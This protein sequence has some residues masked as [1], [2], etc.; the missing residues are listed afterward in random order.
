MITNAPTHALVTDS[1]M[2]AQDAPDHGFVD[3]FFGWFQQS[4]CA[5]HG[6]DS[7]LQYERNRIFLRC[8]S[9]G[10]ESPGWEMTGKAAATLHPVDVRPALAPRGRLAVARKIA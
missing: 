7:I 10:H 3:R 9:C 5:L 2:S 4:L 1:P 6:H 8:T